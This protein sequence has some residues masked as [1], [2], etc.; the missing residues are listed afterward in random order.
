MRDYSL[1]GKYYHRA[2]EQQH[3]ESIYHLGNGLLVLHCFCYFVRDHVYF[4]IY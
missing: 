2:A 4:A 1:A 3:V